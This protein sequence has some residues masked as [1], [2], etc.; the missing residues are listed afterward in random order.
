MRARIPALQHHIAPFLCSRALSPHRSRSHRLRH[1][2]LNRFRLRP[3]RASP[4]THTSTASWDTLSRSMTDC[5]SIVDPKLNGA[6]SVLYLP[7]DVTIPEVAAL[8]TPCNVD[9]EHL[10]KVVASFGELK[11]TR[12]SAS[13]ACS[14][15]RTS[16][17]SPVDASTRCTAGTATSSPW[18]VARWPRRH[19]AVAWSRTSSI[20]IEHYG[21]ILNANRTYYFTRSQP[22]F[23]SS[24]IRDVYE[25]QIP[26]M[27]S[28]PKRA[29]TWL[30]R[31][32]GLC[33][34][35][36]CALD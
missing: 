22:P 4:S 14:T 21:S 16:T 9:V 24:M 19:C 5:H 20:E 29:D 31:A 13:R 17:S 6:P 18:I 32:Y 7:A 25:T 28:S 11:L 12:H 8:K 23:L 3:R 15:C 36:P 27:A 30:D 33:G 1:P 10:P 35:R 34:A 2:A 26:T